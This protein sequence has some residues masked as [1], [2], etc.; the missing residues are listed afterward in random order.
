MNTNEIDPC[1]LTS[2]L[3]AEA[4]GERDRER[5]IKSVCDRHT[6]FWQ[7]RIMYDFG[8]CFI[9]LSLSLCVSLCC[10]FMNQENLIQCT[11]PDSLQVSTKDMD[12]TLSKASRAFKKTSKKV[13]TDAWVF[14]GTFAWTITLAQQLDHS[15]L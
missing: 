2:P 6:L 14:C 3:Q 7:Q 1:L 8:S 13:N 9:V 10:L 11:D 12:S 5:E 15:R 4:G